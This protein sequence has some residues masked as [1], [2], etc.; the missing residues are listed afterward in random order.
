L[1]TTFPPPPLRSTAHTYTLI[2][3]DD[4]DGGGERWHCFECGRQIL[5]WWP[6]QHRRKVVVAGDPS[7]Q[8]VAGQGGAEPQPLQVV[9]GSS[10]LAN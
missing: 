6:P 8:H 5:L 1:A 2:G 10:R 9:V 3:T 4:E 7:V